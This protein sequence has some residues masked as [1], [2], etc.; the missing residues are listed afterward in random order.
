MM[1][2]KSEKLLKLPLADTC[3]KTDCRNGEFIFSQFRWYITLHIFAQNRAPRSDLKNRLPVY[4]MH[5]L[6]N[7]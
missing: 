5:I 4:K 6:T 2:Q 7:F 3:T 1:S